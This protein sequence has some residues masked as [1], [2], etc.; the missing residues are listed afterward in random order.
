MLKHKAKLLVAANRLS[1]YAARGDFFLS[2]T[3]VLEDRV[4]RLTAVIVEFATSLGRCSRSL[5]Q[6]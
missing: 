4:D 5:R 1:R 6:Q 3:G 2:A